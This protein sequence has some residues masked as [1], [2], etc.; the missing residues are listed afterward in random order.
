MDRET[1]R[2]ELAREIA[3]RNDRCGHVDENQICLRQRN[4]APPHQYEPVEK[5]IPF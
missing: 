3:D 4:H 5:V 1:E 2:I